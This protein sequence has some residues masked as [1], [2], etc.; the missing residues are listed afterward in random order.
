MQ[1]RMGLSI[2]GMPSM[3]VIST[4]KVRN[5]G[6]ASAY[7]WPRASK[8][9]MEDYVNHPPIATVKCEACLYVSIRNRKGAVSK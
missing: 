3:G 4:V 5:G 7:H 6:L 9:E 1:L 2:V 8:P